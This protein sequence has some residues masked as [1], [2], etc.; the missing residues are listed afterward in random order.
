[1]LRNLTTSFQNIS[2][3]AAVNSVVM[4]GDSITAGIPSDAITKCLPVGT[5][6]YKL[7]I[8]ADTWAMALPRT[9]MVRALK[10]RYVFVLLGI[11]DVNM[12]HPMEAVRRDARILL[13]Y[14]LL[15][16]DAIVVVQTVMPDG[17]RPGA[18]KGVRHENITS[19][20]RELVQVAT[21][22]GLLIL[23]THSLFLANYNRLLYRI[24]DMLHLGGAGYDLWLR[25]LLRLLSALVPEVSLLRR[26]GKHNS[27]C[28]YA[29]ELQV[30][31][32]ARDPSAPMRVAKQSPLFIEESGRVDFGPTVPDRSHASPTH[33]PT[34]KETYRRPNKGAPPIPNHGTRSFYPVLKKNN[35]YS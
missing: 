21:S 19:V 27:T 3:G 4:F 26:P 22:L 25:R 23:D 29:A 6:F 1:M 15:S 5:P 28:K 20:N 17:P 9:W 18:S 12:H 16:T 33:Q 32:Q 2:Q 14:I 31:M 7:G 34:N 13:R 8:P 11:N 10:P 30:P 24:P 35:S